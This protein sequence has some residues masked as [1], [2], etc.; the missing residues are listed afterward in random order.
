V[1]GGSSAALRGVFD[2]LRRL[3]EGVLVQLFKAYDT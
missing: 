2:T 1:G 3:D